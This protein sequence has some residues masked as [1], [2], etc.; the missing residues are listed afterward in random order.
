MSFK[1]DEWIV[2]LDENSRPETIIVESSTECNFS[3]PYCFR[4]TF[5]ENIQK[6]F[7]DIELFKKIVEECDR[8]NIRRIVFTGFGEPT[9]NPY[10]H[11]MLGLAS[12]RFSRVVLNTN[13][14][15][16]QEFE[17]E[18]LNNLDKLELVIS[19]HGEDTFN[20]IEDLMKKVEEKRGKIHTR[21]IIVISRHNYEYLI[22]ILEKCLKY[23]SIIIMTNIIPIDDRSLEDTCIDDQ[24]CENYVRNMLARYGF[25]FMFSGS[26]VKSVDFKLRTSVFECPFVDSKAMFVRSDGLV[27]PC[28]FMSHGWRCYLQ[29]IERTISPVTY[30]DLSEDS[31]ISVWR[32]PTYAKFRFLVKMRQF[33]CCL[34]CD[35]VQYCTFTLSNEHDCWG[36]SPSC[37]FCPFARKLAYC[38]V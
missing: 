27:S 3:C 6:R 24:L 35:L 23:F 19:I 28:M 22:N 9:L 8:G 21:A 1:I 12:S 15:R 2:R 33:P 10:F 31:I 25:K 7:L 36:N 30:G 17:K 16:I 34:D 11:D 38:P 29:G 37:A 26:C 18:I 5:Y 4:K 32:R 14:S 20:I 13:G